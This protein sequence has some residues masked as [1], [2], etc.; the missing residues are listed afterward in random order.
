MIDFDEYIRQGEPGKN[1]KGIIWQTAI[2]LQQVDGLKP[3]AYHSWFF[4]NALVRANYK[5]LKN[6]VYATNRYLERFLENLLPGENN[7]LKNRELHMYIVAPENIGV[8]HTERFSA[9]GGQKSVVSIG[10]QKD[11]LSG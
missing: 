2:G 9:N 1:E 7:I 8:N 11:G 10:G 6:N 5:N 4:R 3:S